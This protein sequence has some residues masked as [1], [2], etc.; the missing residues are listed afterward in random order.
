MS[1]Y[2]SH[3]VAGMVMVALVVDSAQGQ[4]PGQSQPGR[5]GGVAGQP[6]AKRPVGKP[7]GNID[8]ESGN[9]MALPGFWALDIESVQK[10]LGLT[11]RQKEQLR[12][13]SRKFQASSRQDRHEWEQI[14][15]L[16]PQQQEARATELGRRAARQAADIRKQVAGVLEPEQFDS[17]AK[18]QFHL[19][20]PG[21]LANP[22][23][24]DDLGLSDNQR[25]SEEH[26]SELQSR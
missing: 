5:P 26:T 2:L 3:F 13:I 11:G 21:M 18:T 14:R 8:P 19:Q 15:D 4:Q 10:E 23:V 1:R 22:Q 25:R 16:P 7:G 9:Y 6:G 20:A 17:L 24:L 12:E